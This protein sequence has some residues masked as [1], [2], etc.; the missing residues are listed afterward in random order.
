MSGAGRK[1]GYRKGV[2]SDVLDGLPEPEEG[3]SIVQVVGLRGSNLME[4]V[5]ADGSSSLAMLP[6]KFRK[7]IWVKRGDY[8]IAAS[9][10]G[11][12]ETV[13]KKGGKQGK[14]KY[15][16]SH[17]LYKPQIKHLTQRG[18]WP[19]RFAS[20]AAVETTASA[21][22]DAV[23]DGAEAHERGLPGAGHWVGSQYVTDGAVVAGSA[24]GR[25]AV[26]TAAPGRRAT[27][28]NHPLV[29]QHTQHIDAGDTFRKQAEACAEEDG[30][31]DEY[32]MQ[33]DDDGSDDDDSDLWVNKNKAHHQH[34]QASSS[35]DDDSD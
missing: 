19:A 5:C 28:P 8:L 15:M 6:N 35:E 12:V 25:L 4:I 2:T 9:A 10:H 32:A 27:P 18:L 16:V 7:L 30:Y 20:A 31:D 3:E 1:G 23:F 13:N 29:S 21:Q 11:D 26:A 22:G 33:S 17:I 34:Y 14:V 24:S